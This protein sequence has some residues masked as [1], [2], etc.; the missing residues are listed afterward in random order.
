MVVKI[1]WYVLDFTNVIF[2]CR[3]CVYTILFILRLKI[4]GFPITFGVPRLNLE[5]KLAL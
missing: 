1:T 3:L 5:N 4:E 2:F